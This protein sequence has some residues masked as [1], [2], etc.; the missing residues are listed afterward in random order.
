MLTFFAF[1]I[2]LYVLIAFFFKINIRKMGT[3]NQDFLLIS[4]NK[5]LTHFL[6]L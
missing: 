2:I 3:A 5:I 1:S 4:V 6:K